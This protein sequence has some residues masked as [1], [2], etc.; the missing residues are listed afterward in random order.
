V[1]HKE[2]VERPQSLSVG[3]P[4]QHRDQPLLPDE[5]PIESGSVLRQRNEI[6]MKYGSSPR[7]SKLSPE[8]SL[9]PPSVPPS[10]AARLT[11]TLDKYCASDF[12]TLTEELP[13]G[14]M[15][16]DTEDVLESDRQKQ[17]QTDLCESSRFSDQDKPEG[18]FKQ[19]EVLSDAESSQFQRSFSYRENCQQKQSKMLPLFS[20]SGSL[21]LRWLSDVAR[22]NFASCKTTASSRASLSSTE[23]CIRLLKEKN[24]LNAHVSA[25]KLCDTSSKRKQVEQT[26]LIDDKDKQAPLSTVLNTVQLNSQHAP[27]EVSAVSDVVSTNCKYNQG[28]VGDQN[29]E[30]NV[31]K[32]VT[33]PLVTQDQHTKPGS[34]FVSKV[35]SPSLSLSS[36][37]RLFP[38]SPQLTTRESDNNVL[39]SGSNTAKQVARNKPSEDISSSVMGDTVQESNLKVSDKQHNVNDKQSESAPVDESSVVSD[40]AIQ[41]V[42]P[43]SLDRHNEASSVTQFVASDSESADSEL[44]QVSL[45]KKQFSF[46][47]KSA[48]DIS[49]E[50][51]KLWRSQSVRNK[52]Y[53][54]LRH[55]TGNKE[56]TEAQKVK[57]PYGRSHPLSKLSGE[58]LSRDSSRTI[59]DFACDHDTT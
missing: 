52:S 43:V 8:Q 34:A 51:G 37:T 2:E 22:N 7:H 17:L 38:K 24:K 29:L 50:P 28:R 42:Q 11:P 44:C 53:S 30:T 45:L 55:T 10:D 48:S 39:L 4:V 21:R 49:T 59:K 47:D 14:F 12:I 3:I 54:F 26:D 16:D 40:M 13:E 41:S 20:R 18:E 31:T 58:Y 57:K 36:R 46:R 27:A 23:L 1:K 5:I 15:D 33:L 32:S 35:A 9:C 56:P 19:Q 25:D 6:E